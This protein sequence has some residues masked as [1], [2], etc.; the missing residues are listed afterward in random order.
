MNPR[1]RCAGTAA[2]PRPPAVL[3]LAPRRGCPPSRHAPCRNEGKGGKEAVP[4]SLCARHHR[5]AGGNVL[6]I[7]PLEARHR[8]DAENPGGADGDARLHRGLL[9]DAEQTNLPHV[10]ITVANPNL[11][12]AFR[13]A[14]AGRSTRELPR[15]KKMG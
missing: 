6:P 2:A 15:S 12:G 14:V 1:W 13:A 3:A 11:M 9:T 7:W 4:A 8:G 10:T 5:G